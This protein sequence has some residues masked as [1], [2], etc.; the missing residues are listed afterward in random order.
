MFAVVGGLAAQ[1]DLPVLTYFFPGSPQPDVAAVQDALNE[2]MG[3]RIGAHI[4]L[5]AI[6]WGAYDSQISLMNASGEVYDL[7]FT[8]PWIN[9]FYTNVSQEYLLPLNDLLPEYAPNYFASLTPETWNAVTV[10]GNIMAGINQ[11]IFVKP[12]GPFI[13]TDVLD[14]IGMQEEF[15]ALTSFSDLDP[16]LEAVKAYA[17]SDPTDALEYVTYNLNGLTIPE[18]WGFDPQDFSL[19]V[20]TTDDS[21]QIV[22]WPQTAEYRSAV[23]MA[24][25]YYLAGYAPTDVANWAEADGA[26][27]AGQY[28][29]RLVDIVKPGGLAEI[30][31]RWGQAVTATAIAEPVLTT[32]GVTATLTGV[33]S[34]SEHPELAVQ[35]LELVNTDPVFFNMLAKGLEGSHWEWANQDDL[36]IQPPSGAASFGDTGYN[37]NTDWMFGNVFNAFYTDPSQIGAWPETAELNANA[38]PSPLLGFTFDRSAVETEIAS[39]SAVS[40][41]YADPLNQ[42][43]IE[44]EEGL[45]ALNQALIDAGIERVQAEMQ[46]QV[47]EW[48]AARNS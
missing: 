33:S 36:L 34:T 13:R 21:A 16:I 26:W 37:P 43:L 17:D 48:L 22:I 42:G 45:A 3:E 24:R 23:E 12:F 28:A 29:V 30:E 25:R 27:Q 19:A 40:T 15:A 44:T 5:N 47:D 9:N 32:A 4:E 10:A 11:Q 20:S 39:I 1:D 35:F 18:I 6:D 14:A 46:R 8:A 38:R 41:E 2:Y 31:A 7:A